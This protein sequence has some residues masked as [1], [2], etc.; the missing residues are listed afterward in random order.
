MQI[1]NVRSNPIYPAI[2]ATFEKKMNFWA[3]KTPLLDARSAQMRD[4]K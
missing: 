2:L 3:P 1:M 4:I